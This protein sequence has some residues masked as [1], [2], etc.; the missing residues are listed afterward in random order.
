MKKKSIGKSGKMP[1]TL[2]LLPLSQ[3]RASGFSESCGSIYGE[4]RRK[5]T[6]EDCLVFGYVGVLR[7]ALPIHT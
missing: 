5:A 3:V 7:W 4:S 2:P 1:A 6:P